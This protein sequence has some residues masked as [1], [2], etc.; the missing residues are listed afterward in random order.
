M[1]VQGGLAV[2]TLEAKWRGQREGPGW[3]SV[4]MK[5]GTPPKRTRGN[6]PVLQVTGNGAHAASVISPLSGKIRQ[7][8]TSRD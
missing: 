2:E 4:W 1:L 5:A 3:G 8:L 6:A 7:I